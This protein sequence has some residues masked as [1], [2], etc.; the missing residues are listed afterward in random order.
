MNSTG[1]ITPMCMAGSCTSHGTARGTHVVPSDDVDTD[2]GIAPL[3]VDITTI[4]HKNTYFDMICGCCLP[5]G[6]SGG[7]EVAE[8]PVRRSRKKDTE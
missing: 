3:P 7:G 8:L 5:G 1:P 2:E 4:N 6:G